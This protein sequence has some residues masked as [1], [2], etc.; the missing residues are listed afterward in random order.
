MA[1]SDFVKKPFDPSPSAPFP[2]RK[3][4]KRLRIGEATVNRCPPAN[5]PKVAFYSRGESGSF[6]LRSDTRPGNKSQIRK[7]VPSGFSPV[8]MQM[9]HAF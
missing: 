7:L 6:I 2:W 4:L 1:A 3:G 8:F 9:N 5:R